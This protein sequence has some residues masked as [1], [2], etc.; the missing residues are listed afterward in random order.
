MRLTH[1]TFLYH[2]NGK[3]DEQFQEHEISQVREITL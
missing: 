2:V 1:A 3:I